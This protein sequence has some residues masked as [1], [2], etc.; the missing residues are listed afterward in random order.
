MKRNVDLTEH[1]DFSHRI[2]YG[3]SIGRWGIFPSLNEVPDKAPDKVF[4]FMNFWCEYSYEVTDFYRLHCLCCGKKLI[5]WRFESLCQNCNAELSEKSRL[6]W[7]VRT[8]TSNLR[9]FNLL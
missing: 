7:V 4:G 5:P 6:P 9:I 1:E 8:I 3:L 2:G